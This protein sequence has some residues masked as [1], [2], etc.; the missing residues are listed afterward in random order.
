MA[1]QMTQLLAQ[2]TLDGTLV[3]H[4]SL[5]WLESIEYQYYIININIHYVIYYIYIQYCFETSV[6]LHPCPGAPRLRPPGRPVRQNSVCGTRR[7]PAIIA[8]ATLVPVPVSSPRGLPLRC[9][10]QARLRLRGFARQNPP[11]VEPSGRGGDRVRTGARTD[12]APVGDRSGSTAARPPSPHPGPGEPRLNLIEGARRDRLPPGRDRSTTEPQLTRPL[13]PSLARSRTWPCPFLSENRE[14]GPRSGAVRVRT[15]RPGPPRDSHKASVL[16]ADP[17]FLACP[18]ASGA[19][20][21]AGGRYSQPAEP[22]KV[23][24]QP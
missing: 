10:R 21:P 8:V 11:A 13:R 6:P 2:S 12:A 7:E 18:P 3:N 4:F 5:G 22:A 1:V 19:S 14:R 16:E 17:P 20:A 9:G 24:P 15:P 23:R